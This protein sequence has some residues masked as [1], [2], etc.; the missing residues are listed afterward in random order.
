MI[1]KKEDF[2]TNDGKHYRCICADKEV[3]VFARVTKRRDG[4]YRTHFNEMF[5][6]GQTLLTTLSEYSRF[7]RGKFTVNFPNPKDVQ[8]TRERVA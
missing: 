1:H 8:I 6:C 7:Y 4:G 3:A 2:I 5:V